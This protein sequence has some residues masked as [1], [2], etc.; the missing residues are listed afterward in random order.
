MK[1]PTIP[2]QL[3]PF[4]LNPRS[5]PKSNARRH[6]HTVHTWP[7]LIAPAPAPAP[8]S[9]PMPIRDSTETTG[10]PAPSSVIESIENA[11]ASQSN[12]NLGIQ[13]G[14]RG[15]SLTENE[16]VQLFYVCLALEDFYIERKGTRPFW[17]RVSARLSMQLSRSYSWNS[18]KTQVTNQ[19]QRRRAV[20]AE[21]AETGQ[22]A[23]RKSEL[24]QAID[25][26]IEIEDRLADP[27]A[28]DAREQNEKEE[29]R[30]GNEEFRD[31]SLR[32]T[33]NKRGYP[34]SESSTSTPEAEPSQSPRRLEKRKKPSGWERILESIE[35]VSTSIETDIEH[36]RHVDNLARE[37]KDLK[38]EFDQFR[39]SFK[40][41]IKEE[42]SNLIRELGGVL[43][44][45]RNIS[46]S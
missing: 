36:T 10:S 30:H 19:S 17:E 3:E 31:Y 43:S 29:D 2:G 25:D 20:L 22:G 42:L 38:R 12:P 39:T 45:Q 1:R 15:K 46:S 28:E 8:A 14:K 40:Q 21:M 44:S 32:A 18:C 7:L 23:H 41:E 34:E 9:V 11:R 33:S 35:R 16:K 37:V 4:R 26:W 6:V 24:D 13:K 27:L 5:P